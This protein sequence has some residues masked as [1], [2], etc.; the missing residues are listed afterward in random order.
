[1][2]KHLALVWQSLTHQVNEIKNIETM[3]MQNKVVVELAP[4]L[5]I[6]IIMHTFC[7]KT[8]YPSDFSNPTPSRA[9]ADG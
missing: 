2:C 8:V 7:D 9:Q 3:P 6:L 5:H 1:M 4:F